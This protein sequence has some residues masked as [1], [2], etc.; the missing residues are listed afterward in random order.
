MIRRNRLIATAIITS[1]VITACSDMTA[2]KKLVARGL[3]AA[4]VLAQQR[5]VSQSER[6]FDFTT[7]DVPGALATSA[8]GINARGDIVGSYVDGNHHSHGYLLREG[9]FT[10]IDF[11]GTAFT[12][13]LGI[14]PA[15]EI[16]GDYRLAGEPAVNFHGYMRTADAEFVPV[17]YPGHTN[18]I[19]RRIL[20]DGTMLGCRHDGDFMATMK[21]I[22]ISRH[23]YAE[24]EQFASMENGGT[25]DGRRIVGPY[26]NMATSRTE[27]FLIEDGE[28]TPLLVPNSTL[29]VAW[30]INPAGEIIGNFKNSDGVFHGFVLRD[31]RYVP[32]DVPGAT[33]TRATGINSRG[34]IV[35]VYVT[36]G[37]THGFL[38]RLAR[39]DER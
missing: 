8:S 18:T 23:G 29:T 22:T 33:A 13:A 28:F 5:D 24:I 4:A 31:K 11:P 39:E 36:G 32:I 17:N 6:A 7:I 14:G 16:V 37:R 26:T 34:D 20:P 3:P 38:R 2:P 21:G 9:E 25:P 19:V 12:E 30:D 10:T 15:G 1:V 27:G 35:G